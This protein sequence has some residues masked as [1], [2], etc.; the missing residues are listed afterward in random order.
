MTEYNAWLACGRHPNCEGEF[1]KSFFGRTTPKYFVSNL[2]QLECWRYLNFMNFLPGLWGV[3]ISFPKVT[4]H[5]KRH[6]PSWRE[7][8]W[9][10]HPWD[11]LFLWYSFPIHIYAQASHRGRLPLLGENTT[12]TFI[13]LCICWIPERKSASKALGTNRPNSYKSW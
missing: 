12:F 7:L 9:S 3:C 5:S 10:G 6:G 4:K 1:L 13:M 2:L 11:H 8:L